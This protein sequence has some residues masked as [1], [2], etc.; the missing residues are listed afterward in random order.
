MNDVDVYGDGKPTRVAYADDDRAEVRERE[1]SLPNAEAIYDRVFS[2][3]WF[4]HDSPDEVRSQAIS[5]RLRLLVVGRSS[6]A[7]CGL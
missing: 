6:L 5:L 2:V 4:K 1:G 3:P 7:N